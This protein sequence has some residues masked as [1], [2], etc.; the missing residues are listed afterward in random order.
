MKR[1][2]VGFL[3]GKVPSEGIKETAVGQLWRDDTNHSAL[4]FT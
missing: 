4:L 1:N 2:K 3:L